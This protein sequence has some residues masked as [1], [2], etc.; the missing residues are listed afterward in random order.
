M[1]LSVDTAVMST[2]LNSSHNSRIGPHTSAHVPTHAAARM[3]SIE[4]RVRVRVGVGVGLGLAEA[5]WASHYY[6]WSGLGLGLGLVRVRFRG[7][8][9]HRSGVDKHPQR[10]RGRRAADE[11][12]AA[13]LRRTLE[14]AYTSSRP[15]LPAQRAKRLMFR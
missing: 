13:R 8:M 5:S 9:A 14:R 6:I 15:K 10:A 11:G 3:L 2:V 1:K 7:T 4:V 12:R